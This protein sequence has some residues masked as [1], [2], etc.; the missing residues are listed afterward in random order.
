MLDYLLEE[1]L[2]SQPAPIRS[3]LLQTS[4]LDRLCAPLCAAVIDAGPA[5]GQQD[6]NPAPERA[7]LSSASAQAILEQ[8]ERSNLF[9]V[10]LDDQRRWYRYHHLF[11]EL[12]RQQL[13]S[14]G[15]WAQANMSL[16]A[17]AALHQRASAWYASQNLL[18]EAIQ[19]SL[20]AHEYPSAA[21]LIAGVAQDMLRYSELIT[22]QGWLDA[23]PEELIRARPDLCLYHALAL[24]TG[25]KSLERVNNRLQS[26][27]AGN[28]S[29]P[30]AAPTAALD[31][32]VASFQGDTARGI[33]RSQQALD[34]LTD[35]GSFLGSL[36]VFLL[37]LSYMFNGDIPRVRDSLEQA[38]ELSIKANN[39]LAITMLQSQMADLFVF[40]GYLHKAYDFYQE[41]LR[42]GVDQ[43]GKPLP[44]AGTAYLGLG[45]IQRE[46]NDLDQAEALI[47]RGLELI[48]RW[49]EATA[50]D[51]YITLARIKQARRDPVAARAFIERAAASARQF[52]VS[53]ID[54]R[55]V[56]AYAVR[57]L[58][59]QG[60][61]DGA[62]RCLE[63][64]GLELAAG[65]IDSPKL[66]VVSGRAQADGSSFSGSLI[67]ELEN[68]AAARLLILLGCPE[69]ALENLNT[70]LAISGVSDHRR[71]S[72]EILILMSV[73]YVKLGEDAQALRA[74][75][76]SVQLSAPEGYIR[77]FADEAI[78]HLSDDGDGILVDL[79][80]RLKARASPETSGYIDR[81]LQAC[82]ARLANN[83][84]ALA[85]A[86]ELLSG[87]ELEVLRCLAAGMSNEE[88]AGQL[89]VA[90]STVKSHVHNILNKLN[91]S[92][93]LAAVQSAREAGLLK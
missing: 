51:G 33:A 78:I 14:G 67:Q 9:I 83:A 50:L 60:D 1:A 36:T 25:W 21:D 87:R 48:R 12:L 46:W 80:K 5:A 59:Y 8:L 17:P 54:D 41:A 52:D 90:V 57:L 64:V 81:L 73:A 32:L 35:P 7:R 91:A 61:L 68:I 84:P 19:H 53:V 66:S 92:S 20:A 39:P 79:L 43:N 30:L 74:L 4:I 2:N 63:K 13:D 3:F 27:L 70:L 37:G 34:M 47:Q 6:P 62:R 72:A 55:M 29:G 18:P 71:S 40:E 56:A 65:S 93:R 58:C 44:V 22:L 26:A 31:G 85:G 89:T 69:Q 11:A 45:E 24:V 28:L 38:L 88:I 23:L 86:G 77:L 82:P 16:P 75:E 15:G 10:P 49:G 42:Q 76:R